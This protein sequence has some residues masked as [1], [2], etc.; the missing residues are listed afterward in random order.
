[1]RPGGTPVLYCESLRLPSGRL[2]QSTAFRLGSVTIHHGY[3]FRDRKDGMKSS[4]V[5]LIASA[6][7]T[8]R[9]YM[10]ARICAFLCLI[11]L[12]WTPVCERESRKRALPQRGRKFCQAAPHFA[13]EHHQILEARPAIDDDN[14]ISTHTTNTLINHHS[15]PPRWVA[16]TATAREFLP[17]PS[18]TLALPRHG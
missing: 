16:C 1:M 14:A 8:C 12:P 18:H 7:E 15:Q 3:V 2:V 17:P 9:H 13:M 4:A 11:A 6:L 5:F 10:Y